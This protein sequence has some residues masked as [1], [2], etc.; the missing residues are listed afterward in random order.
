MARITHRYDTGDGA[1]LGFKMA[2]TVVEAAW[3]D[4]MDTMDAMDRSAARVVHGVCGVHGVHK[5]EG[6]RPLDLT[7]ATRFTPGLSQSRDGP[8]PT[9]G[10]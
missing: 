7:P 6:A 3:M 2:L 1:T 4:S 10:R 9:R 8:Y 5:D